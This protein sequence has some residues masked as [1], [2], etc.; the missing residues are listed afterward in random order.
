MKIE[1]F[2]FGKNIPAEDVYLVGPTVELVARNSL[3]PALSDALLEAA[4]EVHST[5]GLFRKRGEFPAP[6]EHEFRI[7][8]DATR[9][10]STGKS[11]LY[12]TFPFWVASLIN[13]IITIVVP[14]G[15]LLLPVLKI[16]PAIYRW[17]IQSRIYP[18]YKTLLEIERDAFDP[19]MNSEKFDELLK[20]LDHIERSLNK[21]K[22]PA[23][24]GDIFYGLR[25]HINFVRDRLLSLKNVL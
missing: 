9:Y 1:L 25:G 16:A 24:F 7:S 18:W 3:H 17:R 22:V 5:A 2:V 12:R 20:K 4:R 14:L 19:A 23:S 10:Y 11:F 6:Q 15:L 21:L 8:P 13:R